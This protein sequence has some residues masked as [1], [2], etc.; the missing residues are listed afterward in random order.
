MELYKS[1]T[2]RKIAL[3]GVA[4]LSLALTATGCTTS[5]GGGTAADGNTTHIRSV[6]A[7]DPHTFRRNSS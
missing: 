2:K 3:L 4:S 5:T 6:F 7:A 1:T